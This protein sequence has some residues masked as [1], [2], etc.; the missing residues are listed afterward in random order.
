MTITLMF[1]LRRCRSIGGLLE[2]MEF[3]CD[4]EQC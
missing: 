2:F 3:L 1:G 4:I